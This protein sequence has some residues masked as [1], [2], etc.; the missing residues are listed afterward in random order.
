MDTTGSISA[1]SH[2]PSLMWHCTR[3]ATASVTVMLTEKGVITPPAEATEAMDEASPPGPN[4]WVGLEGGA[5]EGVG[6]EGRR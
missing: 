4:R 1:S 3:S 6:E 2:C 5:S